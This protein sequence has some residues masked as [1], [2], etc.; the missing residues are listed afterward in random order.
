[1]YAN[2][3]DDL[4]I[5]RDPNKSEGMWATFYQRTG[6]IPDSVDLV[7]CPSIA[8]FTKGK[9]TANWNNGYWTYGIRGDQNSLRSSSLYYK[10][11]PGSKTTA[12]FVATKKLKYPSSFFIVG[13]TLSSNYAKQISQLYLYTNSSTALLYAA[14]TNKQVNVG[15][16]DASARSTSFSDLGQKIITEDQEPIKTSGGSWLSF[17]N[18]D[19]TPTRAYA[20]YSTNNGYNYPTF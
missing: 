11:A 6:Y 15:F 3:F 5:T 8:P 20:Y 12:Y 10:R 17:F 19:R 2:D 9:I 13:D 7:K 16:L 4:I 1:M 14:H 18:K